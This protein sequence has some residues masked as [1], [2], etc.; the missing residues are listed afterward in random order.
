M[1]TKD[2]LEYAVL[3]VSKYLDKKWNYL[4]MD[5]DGEFWMFDTKPKI[6]SINNSWC[7]DKGEENEELVL[8]LPYKGDWK[9]SLV[10]IKYVMGESDD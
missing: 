10:D 3:D 4:A 6:N 1:N 8:N 7:V 2:R 9:D 5:A